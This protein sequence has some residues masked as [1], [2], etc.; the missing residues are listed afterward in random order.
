MNHHYDP[1]NPI[2]WVEATLA[3][4]IVWAEQERERIDRARRY[5][6]DRAVERGTCAVGHDF[7]H[8]PGEA[9]YGGPCGYC[10]SAIEHR[11]TST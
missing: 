3:D 1:R 7:T 6:L 9:K 11:G 10:L 8:G 4:A 5:H 2:P